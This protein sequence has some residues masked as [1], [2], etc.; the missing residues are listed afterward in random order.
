[1]RIKSKKL[2]YDI[3]PTMK[4]ECGSLHWQGKSNNV[5]GAIIAA[6]CDDLPEQPSALLRVWNGRAWQYIE[7]KAALKIAGYHVRN[8]ERGFTVV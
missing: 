3:R 4:V 5:D 6:L 8:T 7:F 2:K 1:M